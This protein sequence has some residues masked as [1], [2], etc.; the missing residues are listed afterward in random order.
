[1]TDGYIQLPDDGAGQKVRTFENTKYDTSTGADA[2]V[3]QEAI[4]VVDTD[5]NPVDPQT[6]KIVDLLADIRLGLA[7]LILLT[8]EIGS[9]PGGLSTGTSMFVDRVLGESR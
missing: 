9:P 6:D 7:H 1:M 8:Q 5:G 4:V 3:V 2:T